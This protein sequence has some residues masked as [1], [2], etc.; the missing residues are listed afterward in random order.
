MPQEQLEERLRK[1]ENE[2]TEIK[3][4]AN[5]IN[6]KLNMVIQY[7]Q[8]IRSLENFR[9]KTLGYSAG[10]LGLG[11]LILFFLDKLLK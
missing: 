11:S 5:S 10:I 3:G 8:R 7:E 2:I 1:V 9:S 4:V 6:D